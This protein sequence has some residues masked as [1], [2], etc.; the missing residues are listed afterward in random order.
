[1]NLKH[2]VLIGDGGDIPRQPIEGMQNI[3]YALEAGIFSVGK[4]AG[5]IF[6]EP[7][8]KGDIYCI[9]AIP[10]SEKSLKRLGERGH[11]H[12]VT[13]KKVG[14]PNKRLDLLMWLIGFK[15]ADRHTVESVELF[16]KILLDYQQ[17]HDEIPLSAYR[18]IEL[19]KD[20]SVR[21][22]VV[23]FQNTKKPKT[24]V[25]AYAAQDITNQEIIE[26]INTAKLPSPYPQYV[27][28]H[29]LM[30]KVRFTKEDLNALDES[31]FINS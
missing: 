5:D 17:K 28:E 29:I 4:G 15:N 19:V 21:Y 7:A 10:G 16:Q 3:T 6:W 12:S 11:G 2:F 1:M 20:G 14:I 27:V 18:T 31:L 25:V 24:Q 8:T 26:M 22:R 9:H 23:T 30:T 13:V